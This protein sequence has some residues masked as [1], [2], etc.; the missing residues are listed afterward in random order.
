M[1]LGPFIDE[2]SSG[3]PEPPKPAPSFVDLQLRQLELADRRLEQQIAKANE[4]TVFATR[5]PPRS[6]GVF[7]QPR[8]WR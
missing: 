3:G 2:R 4:P 7:C 5:Q 6:R 1:S 8:S